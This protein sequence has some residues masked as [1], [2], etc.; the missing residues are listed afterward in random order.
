MKQSLASCECELEWVNSN[1]M[2][3]GMFTKALGLQKGD[4]QGLGVNEQMGH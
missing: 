1:R 2:L 4:V 3:P